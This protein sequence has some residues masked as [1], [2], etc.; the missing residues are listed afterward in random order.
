[1]QCATK[2]HHQ[3]YC[4][5]TMLLNTVVAPN[6]T[7][8]IHRIHWQHFS[9]T[10]QSLSN[11]LTFPDISSEYLRSIDPCNS[12]DTKWNAC[13]FSLQYSYILSQLWQLCSSVNSNRSRNLWQSWLYRAGKCPQQEYP[14]CLH[15]ADPTHNTALISHSRYTLCVSLEDNTS[16]T[17]LTV[18]Y[19]SINNIWYEYSWDNQ[20]SNDHSSSHLT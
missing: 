20:S 19:R 3:K 8:R 2:M 15:C 7:L 9:A 14:A 18:T 5:T 6:T 16:L 11:S 4:A 10:I 1:M 12:S 13:Y 17:L